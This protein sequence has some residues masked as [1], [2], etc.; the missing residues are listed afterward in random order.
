M[1][2]LVRVKEMETYHY[3]STSSTSSSMA[4]ACFLAAAAPLDALSLERVDVELV[5]SHRCTSNA[6]LGVIGFDLPNHLAALPLASRWLEG[7]CLSAEM[8]KEASFM[9]QER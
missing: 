3:P 4:P 8:S 5:A 1:G 6:V 9:Q 7:N 2:N